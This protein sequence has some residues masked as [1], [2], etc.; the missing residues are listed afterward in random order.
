MVVSS[1]NAFIDKPNQLVDLGLGGG[2]DIQN[3]S[4]HPKFSIQSPR[5]FY[6]IIITHI[7]FK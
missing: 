5:S 3:N 4:G 2:L 7:L 1:I 6:R